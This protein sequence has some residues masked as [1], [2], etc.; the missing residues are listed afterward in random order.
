[1]DCILEAGRRT[2]TYREMPPAGVRPVQ[3]F[4][5]AS[6]H[7]RTMFSAYLHNLSG[8]LVIKEVKDILL[9]L[10]FAGESELVLR[11]S[12]R[13]LVDTE[14]LIGST[15]KARQMPLHVLDVVELRSQRI[16]YVDDDHFP[17]GFLL[18]EQRHNTKDLD[19]LHLTRCSHELTD[20]TN[21]QWVVITLCLGLRMGYVGVLPGLVAMSVLG[22]KRRR[23]ILPEERHHS[24]R[25]IHGGGSSCEH[26]GVCPS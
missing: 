7:S 14:P 18:V 17:V 9:V 23:Q 4:S 5:H 25:C 12:V 21:V 10:A 15:K 6:P 3:R 16:I 13:D 22:N 11:L 1:M 8:V 2:D 20:L 26:S 19:L 24:S